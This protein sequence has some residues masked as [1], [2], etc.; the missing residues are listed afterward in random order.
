MPFFEIYSCRGL[1]IRKQFTYPASKFYSQKEP[2]AVFL[3]TEA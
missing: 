3:L 2:G 1:D